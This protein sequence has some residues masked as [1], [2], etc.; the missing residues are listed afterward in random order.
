MDYKLSY[1]N[2]KNIYTY[3]LEGGSIKHKVRASVMHANDKGKYYM[4]WACSDYKYD[5]NKHIISSLR[6]TSVNG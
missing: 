4:H 5:D 2:I 3:L 1:Y 6:A